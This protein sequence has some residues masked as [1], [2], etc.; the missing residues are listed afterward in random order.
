[1]EAEW[2]G[3]STSQ[4]HRMMQQFQG[5]KKPETTLP[6]T[7]Q[8][9]WPHPHFWPLDLERRQFFLS[10]YLLFIDCAGS[11]LQHMGSLV[12]AC[13]HL[14]NTWGMWD[15]VPWP[16]ME[17][18]PPALGAWGLS[19]WTTKEVPR[20]NNSVNTFPG[21]PSPSAIERYSL[22]LLQVRD[23]TQFSLGQSQGLCSFLGAPGKIIIIF[24]SV[25]RGL[26]DLS[27]PTR[28][29]TPAPCSGST[30]NSL[31]LG[32]Q[33]VNQRW[34]LWPFWASG[35]CLHPLARTLPS[36]CKASVCTLSHPHPSDLCLLFHF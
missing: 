34:L 5:W 23:L 9:A 19:H 33:G 22:R 1:M 10:K 26:W 8:R 15:L 13:E 30:T 4:G 36:F 24:F 17:P 28:D 31:P 32:L 12:A 16:G 6:Q 35:G 11:W 7:L 18:R 21:L 27:S 25:P 29:W 20:R 3:A 14:T 2:S